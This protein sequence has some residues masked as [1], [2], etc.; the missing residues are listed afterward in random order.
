MTVLVQNQTTKKLGTFFDK[1]IK[2]SAPDFPGPTKF[3]SAPFVFCCRNVGPLATL[4]KF[5]FSACTGLDGK[6][7][8]CKQKY[9]LR[10]G[11]CT[12]LL[13]LFLI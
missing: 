4:N 11:S 7:E 1:S 2:S 10:K 5:Q 3:F 13:S 6:M 12:Q 8:L 9:E